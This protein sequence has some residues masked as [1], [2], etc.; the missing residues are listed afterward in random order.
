MLICRNPFATNPVSAVS[1]FKPIGEIMPKVGFMVRLVVDP[2]KGLHIGLRNLFLA[3]MKIGKKEALE[4]SLVEVV[5]SCL[6]AMLLDS[7]TKMLPA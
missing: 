4:K 2:F 3:S 5:D 7:L 6:V 1:A